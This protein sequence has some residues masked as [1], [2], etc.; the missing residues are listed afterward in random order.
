MTCRDVPGGLIGPLLELAWSLRAIAMPPCPRTRCV[1]DASP[2]KRSKSA[3][4]HMAT[5]FAPVV[6]AHRRRPAGA[7]PATDVDQVRTEPES[8][9][10][11][12]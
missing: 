4:R 2:K 11:G 8:G 12:D 6:P 5:G 1:Y 7:L 10:L 3:W 9:T